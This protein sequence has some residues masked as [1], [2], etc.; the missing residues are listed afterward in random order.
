[1]ESILFSLYR[2]HQARPL[3][4]NLAKKLDGGSLELGLLRRVFREYHNIDVGA[5]SYGGCFDAKYV[6]AGTRIGKFCSFANPIYIFAVNHKLQAVTTHPFI[7][8]PSVGI[9]SENLREYNHVQI[10][11]D[12]WMGLNAMI[13]PSVSCV[14]DGAVIAA[15]AV[16]AKDVP[17]YAVVG[18]IPAKIIKYRFPED[19]IRALL[20]IKWW[21]WEPQRIFSFHKEFNSTDAFLKAAQDCAM[22]R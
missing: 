1:V 9:I 19:V 17:P 20:E 13:M 4:I 10:G 2:L 6:A 16:V 18:G 21:D 8:N 12:V 15:G 14:G 7:Y 3:V 22:E 5:Y 11:N